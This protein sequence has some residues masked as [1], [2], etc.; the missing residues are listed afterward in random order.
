[1]RLRLL[2]PI[3]SVLLAVASGQVLAASASR[4]LQSISPSNNKRVKPGSRPTF[5]VRIG[6]GKVGGLAGHDYEVFI[7]VSKSARKRSLPRAKKSDPKVLAGETLV[8]AMRQAAPPRGRTFTYKPRRYKHP[9][10]WLNKGGTYY[11]QAYYVYCVKGTCV[12]P[13]RVKTLRIR[14]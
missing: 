9:S 14:G 10:Y 11:W 5:T 7:R 6:E 13:G 4:D 12:H 3:V 2:L 8:A 1:M